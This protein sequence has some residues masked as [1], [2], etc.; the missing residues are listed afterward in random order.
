MDFKGTRHICNIRSHGDFTH[1]YIKT[2]FQRFLRPN[3]PKIKK[4]MTNQCIHPDCD[5]TPRYGF[6]GDIVNHCRTHKE[7]G[8][9]DQ[10]NTRCHFTGCTK[11]AS[12]GTETKKPVYCAEHKT[13]D[14]FNVWSKQ[15]AA[16]GCSKTVHF[17]YVDKKPTHC[18][19]HK[20][21]DMI[22]V[23]HKLCEIA[24]CK[25]R[26]SYGY[27]H[28]KPLYCAT[29]GKM[30]SAR[31][32]ITRWCKHPG[33]RIH[34]CFGFP[35]GSTEYCKAHKT[36]EMS[37]LGRVCA[38]EGCSVR[39]CFGNPGFGAVYCCNHKLNGM[40]DV[41]N[42]MCEEQDCAISASY[43]YQ[44]NRP[45]WCKYHCAKQDPAA[46]L[47]TGRECEEPGCRIISSFGYRG[48]RPKFCSR[49]K[50][51][52]MINLVE[53]RKLCESCGLSFVTTGL[54]ESGLCCY[55][56][57]DSAPLR[58]KEALI[59][60]LLK[61]RFPEVQFM[62]NRY[63]NQILCEARLRYR[64]DFWL[65]L[66]THILIVEVDE[67]AHSSYE[68]ICEVYRMVNIA[69]ACGGKNVKFIRYNPDTKSTSK[70]GKLLRA[71]QN[72]ISEQ[73]KFL[74]EV[75]YLF[76]PTRRVEEAQELLRKSLLQY[77]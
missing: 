8:Q 33:C 47:V 10:W 72:S 59:G 30:E 31:D 19:E 7:E 32:V 49:H 74:L 53:K 43:G 17:G 29:H 75:D 63:D 21:A 69:M 73:P 50:M 46:W 35:G 65:E 54:D 24:G 77:I 1:K 23:K 6:D 2:S 16:E 45:R 66:P 58:R 52:D 42:K 12:F 22:D 36:D 26:A 3:M 57:P 13:E 68:Q 70:E 61:T 27:T 60:E 39:P 20:A 28:Q 4:R 18:L 67:F 14:M 34:P 48:D 37:Y 76:Y 40:I 71:V 51:T 25:T 15:C 9:L 5:R 62:Q 56:R 11:Q 44:R 41:M 38:F 64:P 55:C